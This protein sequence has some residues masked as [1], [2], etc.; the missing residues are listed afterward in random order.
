MNDQ[1][2]TAGVVQHPFSD[3]ASCLMEKAGPVMGCHRDKIAAARDA[4]SFG[5]FSRLCDM[6]EPTDGIGINA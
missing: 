4:R 3:P 1:D 6:Q 2:W 5:I